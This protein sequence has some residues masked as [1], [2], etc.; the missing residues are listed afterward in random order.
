[1]AANR[2]NHAGTRS[3]TVSSFSPQNYFLLL[4]SIVKAFVQHAACKLLVSD[5]NI[6]I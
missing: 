3:V 6:S 2:E 1:M 5:H 4:S